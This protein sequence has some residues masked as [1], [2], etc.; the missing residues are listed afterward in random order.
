MLGIAV[1]WIDPTIDDARDEYDFEVFY[2]MPLFPTVDTS[3]AYQAIIDP[4]FNP[5]DD[6]AHVFSFRLRKTF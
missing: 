3:F 1:N 4:A 2:R 5:E 6:L